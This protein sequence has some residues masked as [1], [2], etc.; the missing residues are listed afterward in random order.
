MLRQRGRAARARQP[1]RVLATTST[2]PFPHW[3]GKVHR[4]QQYIDVVFSS[5][6][7]IVQRGRSLVR[8]TRLDAEVL[9][10]PV[11]LCPA[12]ELLWSSAFVQERERY[13]GAAVLHLLHAHALFLD[14]PRSGRAIR[15]S[16]GR[17]PQLPDPLS[18]RRTP[19]A[20]EIFRTTS[21]NEL[22]ERLQKQRPEPD[23]RLCLGTLLSREQYLFDVEQLGYA[24]ARLRP[25]G[26]MTPEQT[27]I[28]TKAIETGR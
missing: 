15:R 20:V 21:L 10:M 8:V 16:L 26:A 4:E 6:N 1:S 7:G 13:D 19:I 11:A 28:W 9:G 27:E 22:I 3:L 24:D 2:C 23:N 14:W 17:A 5:G 12:E 18:V 25:S